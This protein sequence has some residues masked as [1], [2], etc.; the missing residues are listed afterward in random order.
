VQLAR[1]SIDSIQV[2][3]PTLI[4]QGWAI[5]YDGS[6]ALDLE[7]RVGGVALAT[8]VRAD[9]RTDVVQ[10]VP[11]ASPKCGFAASIS[12]LDS[13]LLESRLESLSLFHRP[14]DQ[15]VGESFA[16]PPEGAFGRGMVPPRPVMPRESVEALDEAMSV[17]TVYLE[18]GTGGSTRLASTH[19]HL[20]IIGIES[21]WK[22]LRAVKHELLLS[23]TTNFNLFYCDIGQTGEWGFPIGEKGFRSWHQ[24]PIVPWQFAQKMGH[25]PDLVLIDG[26][27]RRS[28]F[29]ASLIF[30]S[31]GMTI[32]FDDYRDRDNY[33]S[34]ERYVTPETLFDRTA[35]FVRP[36]NLNINDIWI[37]FME[38]ALDPS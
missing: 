32:L 2:I 3:G 28:C 19:R 12:L 22:W 34:V 33:H 37:E 31:P 13:I 20:A 15:L 35:R 25:S 17:S 27:F 26:R 36:R 16:I 9:V 29:L 21:D 6:P 10:S 18:Y 23:G 5:A 1:S 8:H 30:G 11:N 14:D 4:V 7:F 24:Y 38:A